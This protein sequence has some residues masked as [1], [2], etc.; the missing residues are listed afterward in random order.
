MS[1]TAG[2]TASRFLLSLF[3]LAALLTA[4][5]SKLVE[6][7]HDA[8]I[9]AGLEQLAADTDALFRDFEALDPAD[10]QDLY[11]A[12]G[13][14]ATAVM[15]RAQQRAAAML[16]DAPEGEYGIATAGFL[17]DYVRHLTMLADADR[18]AGPYGPLPA[19]VAL[20]AA[21]MRDALNDAL[22]H[23]RDTLARD[24]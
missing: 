21:A 5:C 8:R 3:C 6:P 17:G 10:R 4:A 24:R 12:L 22:F 23:E 7:P 2:R 9:V 18:D 13:A 15:Q 14:G 1:D 20:R 19:L 11:A 16:T